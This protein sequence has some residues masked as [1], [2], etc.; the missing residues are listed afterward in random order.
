[1]YDIYARNVIFTWSRSCMQYIRY[2]WY[3]YYIHA[4]YISLSRRL[5]I[6]SLSQL[7]R[8]WA[9]RKRNDYLPWRSDFR[10]F[11]VG[12]F[13]PFFRGMGKQQNEPHSH[14]WQQLGLPKLPLNALING[15]QRRGHLGDRKQQRERILSPRALCGHRQ[16]MIEVSHDWRWIKWMNVND[17]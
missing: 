16:R 9:Q 11:F 4:K 6:K 1:M 10:F 14:L 13:W 5:C 8:R 2:I 3:M 17:V 15:L 7:I 12:A